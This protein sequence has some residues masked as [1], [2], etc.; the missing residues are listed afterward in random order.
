MARRMITVEGLGK[1]YPLGGG[2]SFDIRRGLASNLRSLM[3][4]TGE[5]FWAVRDVSFNVEEGQVFG[6]IGR[7]G[8]GKSTLLKMLSRITTPTEGRFAIEGR[9][10]SLLEV[11]TGFHSDLTGRENVH[12][13]GTILGMR[14]AEVKAKFDEIVEFSG[15]AP[16]I[17]TPV[18]HY[19]SGQ[20]VRLAFA[21]AA[22]LEPEVL[23]IDEV[24]AVGDAEFQRKCL[25]KMKDVASHGRTILFVS[26]NMSA[27]NSLCEQCILLDHG[28]VE[29]IGPTNQ[30][31]ARYLDR[32]EQAQ[33]EKHVGHL[34]L[35]RDHGAQITKLRWVDA[36]QNT[37]DHAKVT[38]RF[39]LEIT[40]QVLKDGLK[41]QPALRL[42]NEHGEQIFTNTPGLDSDLR[43]E[44]GTHTTIVWIPA[45]LLNTGTVFAT[46]WLLTWLPHQPH[47]VLENIMSIPVLDDVSSPTHPMTDH[48]LGGVIRPHLHWERIVR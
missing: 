40:H 44:R 17:D 20:K 16:F 12:L 37:I 2:R 25:G 34:P 6:V 46:V 15:V 26:H 14:R 35:Q 19:S 28:R 48:R 1:R 23:V 33:G 4:G 10:S 29:M 32:G 21:V 13:N 47:Q 41:P 30:V 36:E 31:T 5:P 3:Q 45:D 27:V 18:K 39:G 11:G 38:E 8:A 7:N 42:H 24:L 9:L 43:Y 22:H